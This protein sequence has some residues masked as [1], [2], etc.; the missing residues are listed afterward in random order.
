MVEQIPFAVVLRNG[1]VIGPAK[2]RGEYYAFVGVGAVEV[3]G[4]GV[5]DKVG[6]ASG[7]GQIIFA[8]EF[9]YPGAFKKAAIGVCA[10]QGNASAI[11]NLNVLGRFCELQH[12]IAQLG[13][14]RAVSR[15]IA[16]RVFIFCDVTAAR[17]ALQLSPQMPPNTM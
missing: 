17:P 14:F 2:Y 1:V 16:G 11:E 8:V 5:G 12:V 7:V 9:V 13:N 3:V 4:N 15:L 10:E 6:V